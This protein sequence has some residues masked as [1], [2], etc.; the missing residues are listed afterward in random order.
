MFADR[1]NVRRRPDRFSGGLGTP[2]GGDWSACWQ[3]RPADPYPAQTCLL[4]GIAAGEQ[5]TYTFG[6]R[7]AA[8]STDGDPSSSVLRLDRYNEQDEPWPDLHPADNE[9]EFRIRYA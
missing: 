8:E 5:R 2:D 7:R 3:G 4:P 1:R 6:F 9:Y